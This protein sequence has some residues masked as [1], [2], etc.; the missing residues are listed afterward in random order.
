MP[1]GWRN[2]AGWPACWITSSFELR[3][4][5]YAFTLNVRLWIQTWTLNFGF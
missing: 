3:P 4:L 2:I 1:F 5:A